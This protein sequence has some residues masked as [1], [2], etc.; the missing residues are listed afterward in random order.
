MRVGLLLGSFDPVHIGHIF[1]ATAAL[2]ENLVDEVWFVPSMQNPWKT[3]STDF[4]V[5]CFMLHLATANIPNVSVCQLDS[6]TQAPHYTSNTLKLIRE[7]HPE[8]EYYLIVGADVATEIK[9]WNEGNWILNN[10][11]LLTVSRPGYE[12]VGT[13]DIP[14]YLDVSSTRIRD[15]IKRDLIVYP[16]LPFE[17]ETFIKSRNLYK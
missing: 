8:N 5:R 13:I 7:T 12:N 15:W 2:N 16:L 17:V 14:V 9:N 1:M 4:M 3:E 6:K 10:F 11:Y